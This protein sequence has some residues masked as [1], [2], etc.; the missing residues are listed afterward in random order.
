MSRL[1]TSLVVVALVG[2]IV[3]APGVA[4]GR[5]FHAHPQKHAKDNGHRDASTL[6]VKA[7]G[8]S[9]DERAAVEAA[10]GTVTKHID[11]LGLDVVKVD[12]QKKDAARKQLKADERVASVEVDLPRYASD[13]PNDANLYYESQLFT[14]RLPAAWDVTHGSS[15]IDIAILDTG[16]DLDHPDLAP[17]IVAGRDI[18]NNDSVAQDDEGHG[19]F[20]AGVAA[21]DA[22]NSIGVAGSSYSARIMPVKVLG[23]DGSG[24]DS[25]IASGIVWATDHGAEV[26]NLSLGGPGSTA[27]L[28]NSVAYAESH[29][30]VVVAASG[31]EQSSAPSYPAAYSTVLAVGATDEYGDIVQFS[32]RGSYLDVVAQGWNVVS[33][34]LASGA[35]E[36][37]AA[38][39]GTSFSSPLVA[40]VAALLKAKNTS[41]SPA[42]VRSKITSTAID[43]GPSGFDVAY[44]YGLVD[45]YAAVGG[46]TA[47]S[48][49]PAVRDANEPDGVASLAHAIGAP[50]SGTIS[51]ESDTDWYYVDAS[52]AGNIVVTATPPLADDGSNATSFDPV[53]EAFTPDLKSLG[54][55]N[56]QTDGVT[57]IATVPVGSAGRY[58]FEISNASTSRSTGPASK[59]DAYSLTG[60]FTPAVVSQ[61]TPGSRVTIDT[62][63]PAGFATGVSA[64]VHPTLRF[65]FDMNKSSAES[66]VVMVDGKSGSTVSMSRSYD[67]PSKV[68]T[69]TPSAPLSAG[70]TYVIDLLAPKDSLNHDIDRGFETRFTVAPST[71]KVLRSDFNKDG[72][73]DVAIGVPNEDAASQADAGVVQVF[74][75]SASGTTTGGS[76]LWFQN[77]SNIPDSAEANDRF[78]AAL[79]TGDVNN[80]GYA[81]LIVGV[82]GEDVGS[83]K[84]AGMVE[85]ILGSSSG[86]TG[87]GSTAWTEDT[88]G[89]PD[90][91]EAT[92]RFGAALAVGRFDGSTGADVAIGV[93]G[94]NAG[95][96]A[97]TVLRGSSSGLTTTGA[98]EWTQNSAGIDFVSASGDAFGFALAAGDF[99]GDGNDDLAIGAPFDDV[100]SSNEGSVTMMRGSIVGL[101]PEGVIADDLDGATPESGDLF[102][103]SVEVADVGGYSQ[104]DGY[105]DLVIGVPGED[106]GAGAVH[107][108]FSDHSDPWIA[109]Q[110]LDA[111]SLGGPGTAAGAQ[112]G[113][114]VAG[115]NYGGK[116]FLAVGVPGANSNAGAVHAYS[117]F[118]PATSSGYFGPNALAQLTHAGPGDRF[119]AALDVA[120]V[121]GDKR[122]DVVVGAPTTLVS[123]IAG[124]G[125]V[126]VIRNAISPARTTVVYHQNA[127]GVSDSAE[128]NDHFGASVR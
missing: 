85:V 93:V 82:P 56:A 33:T 99:Q 122:G 53:I 12:P 90:T 77:S 36:A 118:S 44:G 37:Y 42:Q 103:E 95:A 14:S 63:S 100:E 97:V 81:D 38:G 22:N 61:A 126:S 68:L 78:G 64:A 48:P 54:T 32:N 31:N 75:G 111:G 13:I 30:V 119:G 88:S 128:T 49:P 105:A 116:G 40:G 5:Q 24:L 23:S 60:L 34:D 71:S 115:R 98:Q 8:S 43:R 3:A 35:T 59:P 10:G 102:G 15:T 21:G 72:Y 7:S 29:G 19:T 80:D 65:A 106:S 101:R 28:A 70:H 121:D 107:I 124:A 125:A 109:T 123:S 50:S 92:D 66:Q 2:A 89:V 51:P 79:A 76:Q 69:L 94:E 41:F 120:D 26:I 96:G 74:Y 112:F 6:L 57:E 113:M 55:T 45:A 1:R 87:S 47:A 84:D 58:Y 91:A 11:R 114:T 127:S 46:R 20:V 62:A 52:G 104:A 67:V 73:D 108:V 18:V 16:V 17:R 4:S 39:A 83:I 110:A 86:L 117:T 9:A 25:D 27:A